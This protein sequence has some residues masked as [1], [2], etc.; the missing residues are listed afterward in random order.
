MNYDDEEKCEWADCLGWVV[1]FH[2]SRSQSTSI[3]AGLGRIGTGERCFAPRLGRGGSID[4]G[5][6]RTCGEGHI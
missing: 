2:P 1:C 5:E 4:S 6:A 3:K